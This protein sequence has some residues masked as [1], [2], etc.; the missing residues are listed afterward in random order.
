[1]RQAA[2]ALLENGGERLAMRRFA[3]RALTFVWH[4]HSELTKL[5]QRA[6]QRKTRLQC[7]A[8]KTKPAFALMG[9]GASPR[10]LRKERAFATRRRTS[11][12]G[13]GARNEA[14][15][16]CDSGK[17][18]AKITGDICRPRTAASGRGNTPSQQYGHP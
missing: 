12:V 4:G 10:A 3:R 14:Q 7:H 5:I 17:P 2:F 16:I 8:V 1:M 18:H 9:L 13:P 11:L 6:M 15:V